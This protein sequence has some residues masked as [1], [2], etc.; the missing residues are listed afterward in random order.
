MLISSRVRA[1]LA[2]GNGD[3]STL[4]ANPLE[5]RAHGDKRREI[6]PALVRHV[7][8]SIESDV[9]DRV[10]VGDEE[11]ALRKVALHHAE[12]FVPEPRFLLEEL[13]SIFGER[14]VLEPEARR[15]DVRL[16]AVLLE[17]EPFEHLGALPACFRE[18]RRSLGQVHQDGVGLGESLVGIELEHRDAAVRIFG[19]KLVGPRLAVQD[20]DLDALVRDPELRHEEA[21]FVSVA[22]VEVV[23]EA[24]QRGTDTMCSIESSKAAKY[25]H[26]IVPQQ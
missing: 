3:V 8:V 23:V 13:P 15:G 22:R 5:P 2:C 18:E 17:K 7:R 14:E 1:L 16:V 10:L 9:G 20:V 12:R 4:R 24:D 19:E 25:G 21:N 6:E 11:R 26:P